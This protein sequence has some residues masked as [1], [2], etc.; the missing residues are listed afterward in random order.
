MN[1]FVVNTY[2]LEGYF[3]VCLGGVEAELP[4]RTLLIIGKQ[5]RANLFVAVQVCQ[6]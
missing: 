4:E 5:G 3:W 6:F 2:D 1:R